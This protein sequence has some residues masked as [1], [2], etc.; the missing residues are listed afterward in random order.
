MSRS[1]APCYT[2]LYSPQDP[3]IV[4]IMTR[5]ADSSGLQMGTDILG[6]SSDVEMAGFMFDGLASR[7]IEA[8]VAFNS[9]QVDL[10]EG[11]C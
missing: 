11:K 10:S 9:S 7:Q 3:D 4:A 5:V 6:F 8:A 2:L 1:F